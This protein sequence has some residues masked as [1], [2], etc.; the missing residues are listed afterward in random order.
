[1]TIALHHRLTLPALLLA[2]TGALAQV[3]GP[4]PLPAPDTRTMGAAASTVTRQDVRK[5]ALEQLRHHDA[6]VVTAGETTGAPLAEVFPGMYA[7]MTSGR[8]RAEVAAELR[9]AVRAGTIQPSFYRGY[10][11]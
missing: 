8:S 5:Q 7:G 9:E 6:M 3:D 10:V 11:N 1:M 2:A 4:A